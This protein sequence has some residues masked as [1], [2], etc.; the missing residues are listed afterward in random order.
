MVDFIM[1]QL[2]MFVDDGDWDVLM[3]KIG[4]EYCFNDD[5]MVY[6]L[7]MIGFKSGGFNLIFLQFLFDE[8]M[9]M[10][11][12]VGIKLVLV[13]CKVMFNVVFFYYD[14]DDLQVVVFFLDCL[15]VENVVVVIVNGF[16][17]DFVVC[18]MSQFQIEFGLLLFDDEF[19]F[20]VIQNL[21]DVVWV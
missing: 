5:L 10:S 20:F 7:V 2:L 3:L 4:F 15:L 8:E 21:F 11:Y 17:F 13:N 14:Y 18:L 12:E 19:D 16:E 9:V 1:Q 6:G